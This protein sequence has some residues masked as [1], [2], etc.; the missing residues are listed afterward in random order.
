MTQDHPAS[1]ILK[2][3]IREFITITRMELNISQEYMATL[4]DINQSSYSKR[5]KGYS[6]FTLHQIEVI[7]NEFKMSL[8][9]F[10]LK[11]FC[12]E[13]NVSEVLTDYIKNLTPDDIEKMRKRL[14]TDYLKNSNVL[15]T[16]IILLENLRY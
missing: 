16:T 3:T 2:N 11:A 1:N 9:E 14:Q 7:A 6:E 13:R 15:L 5:E 8:P 4:L 12:K 10:F